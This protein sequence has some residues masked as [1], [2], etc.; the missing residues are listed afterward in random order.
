MARPRTPFPISEG[1]GIFVGV[2]AWDLLTDGQLEIIRAALI[3]SICS[4]AWFGLRCWKNRT[5]NRH[6]MR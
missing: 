1:F 4:L 2:V 3:A 5:R 6:P